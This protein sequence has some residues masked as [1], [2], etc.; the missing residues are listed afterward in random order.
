[1]QLKNVDIILIQFAAET[2]LLA[3]QPAPGAS[4]ALAE[5]SADVF[6]KETM[7]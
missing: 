4:D 7:K 2:C 1:M 6:A 5:A 3:R